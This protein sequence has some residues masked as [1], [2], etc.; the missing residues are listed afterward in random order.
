MKKFF[1]FIL[2]VFYF[3]IF[4]IVFVLELVIDGVFNEEFW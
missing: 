2:I 1:S 4:N 3:Y